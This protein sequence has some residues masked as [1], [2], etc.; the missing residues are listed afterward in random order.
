MLTEQE[1]ATLRHQLIMD[2]CKPW[3][4]WA[5]SDEEL[6]MITARNEQ[7]MKEAI[8]RAKNDYAK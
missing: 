8:E 4:V 2:D 5:L 3:K 7:Y 6:I 1:R